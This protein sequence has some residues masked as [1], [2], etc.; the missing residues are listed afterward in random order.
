MA[1]FVVYGTP[2]S[3]FVRKVEVVLKNQGVDYDLEMINIM[4]MP[5]WFLEIS[6][7]RR[8]PVLRD[9]T[10]GEDGV[11]GTIADSS[12]ICLYLDRKL[13]A[14]LYGTSDFDAGR[15]AWIEEYADTE[16]AGSVGMHVFRP[17]LFPRMAG[18]DSDLDAA[19]K[20]FNEILP[21]RFD[22][23]ESA[24][25]GREYF[26]GD[27][28]TLADI[29]VGTQMAQLSLVT[30]PIDAA[31]WPALAAHTEAIKARTGFRES[32]EV[33][34]KMLGKAIPEKIDLSA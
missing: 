20:G 7:A 22:Y 8:I 23:L 25:D 16:L 32:L 1:D 21:T 4:A 17:I 13:N 14:G 29:A 9:R 24:L 26:V 10:L 6:P 12:A 34:N 28:F 27:A 33:C 11:Q 15:V 19:R 5:D 2:V 31:R 30:L 18:K 3:P